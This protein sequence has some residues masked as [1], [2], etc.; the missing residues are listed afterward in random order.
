[1]TKLGVQTKKFKKILK[2]RKVRRLISLWDGSLTIISLL[3][4][5]SL[6]YSYMAKRDLVV[7][8]FGQITAIVSTGSVFF[9]SYMLVIKNI[10]RNVSMVLLLLGSLGLTFGEI[11]Q[12]TSEDIYNT[13]PLFHMSTLILCAGILLYLNQILKKENGKDIQSQI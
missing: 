10:R 12:I 6:V 9:F 7:L 3:G 5:L 4:L 13:E 11:S 8:M 1:M 2:V